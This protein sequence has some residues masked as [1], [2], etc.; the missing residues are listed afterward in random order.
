MDYDETYETANI[1]ANT[2][3]TTVRRIMMSPA[4]PIDAREYVII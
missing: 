1:I 2:K 4:A 3:M